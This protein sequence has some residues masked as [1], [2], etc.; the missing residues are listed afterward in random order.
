MAGQV[1]VNAW[2][3]RSGGR[4]KD[5]PH[6]FERLFRESYSEVYNFVYYSILNEQAT[7]D[8]VAEAFLRAARYFDRFDSTRAKFT[9]WVKSI[10]RNCIIDYYRKRQPT[11]SIDEVP[12]SAFASN[13]DFATD[14]E[15]ADL[16]TRLLAILGE[17]ERRL[18]YLKYYEGLRNIDIANQLDLNESTVASRLHRAL[19]KMSDAYQRT[20][21]GAEGAEG[22][23]GEKG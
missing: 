11:S 3:K 13:E 12:E 10:A 5:R 7:E 19:R 16:A 8:V 22:T 9:T 20:V 14:V 23:K 21:E 6:E 18:V 1:K 2:S 15:N 4:A 17:D